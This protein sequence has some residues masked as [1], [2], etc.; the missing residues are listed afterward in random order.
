MNQAKKK[1][2]RTIGHK[3]N[4][5]VI[6]SDRGMSEGIEEELQRALKDHE[7]IKVKLAFED[8][9]VRKQFAADLCATCGAELIQAIGKIILIYRAAKKPNPKLSN[10][11]RNKHLLV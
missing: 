2:L 6:V 1:Q 4:P 7:L 10:L 5:V 8:P 3:L 9:A 11:E